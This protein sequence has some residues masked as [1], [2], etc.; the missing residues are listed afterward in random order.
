MHHNTSL[1]PDVEVLLSVM[2]KT[3]RCSTKLLFVLLNF[4]TWIFLI[5]LTKFQA[6][7]RIFTNFL[8]FEFQ[9]NFR[10]ASKFQN[11]N[12][13]PQFH[14]NFGIAHP[15]PCTNRGVKCRATECTG[16]AKKGKYDMEH[17][18]LKETKNQWW[19]WLSFMQPFGQSTTYNGDRTNGK[20]WLCFKGCKCKNPEENNLQWN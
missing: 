20:L 8:N 7:F 5:M 16:V 17:F 12:Q 10:I 9:Q 19:I 4:Y 6:N 18:T 2:V 13:I 14:Q 11:F 3:S 1:L 15:Y